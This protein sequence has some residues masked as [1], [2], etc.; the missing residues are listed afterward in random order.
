MLLDLEPSLEQQSK[1]YISLPYGNSIIL[2][3]HSNIPILFLNIFLWL[4]WAVSVYAGLTQINMITDLH[5][6][7]LHF[8]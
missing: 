2:L 8:L 1:L 4:M 7:V 6:L 5:L 3:I